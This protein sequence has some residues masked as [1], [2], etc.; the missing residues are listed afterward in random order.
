[1]TDILKDKVAIVTGA[2]RGIGRETALRL[3]RAGATVMLAARS[4]NQLQEVSNVLSSEGHMAIALHTDVANVDDV[5]RLVSETMAAFKR[6]DILVNAA[7][8]NYVSNL[9]TSDDNAWKRVMDVN[10]YGVYLCTKAV[11]PHMIRRKDGRVINI[12]SVAAKSGAAYNS[13]YASAK[14]AVLAFTKSAALE[15]ARLGITVN[16]I[17]PWHVDTEM[18][19]D[20]MKTRGAMFGR[21][22][23]EHL[24]QI[25]ATNPQRRLITADEVAGLALFLCSPDARGINGQ[26][27][28]QC[29]G[30]E[31]TA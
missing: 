12:A 31:M 2:G 15:T 29:G 22:A 30:A 8:A 14:A 19:R 25:V 27:I 9:V 26:A 4:C 1:M 17:C 28:N 20:A 13:A 11:L 21:T 6:I 3:G 10:L 23:E 7:G 16:A 18:M 24:S 5:R